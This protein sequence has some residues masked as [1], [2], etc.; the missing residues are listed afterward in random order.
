MKWQFTNPGVPANLIPLLVLAKS[1]PPGRASTACAMQLVRSFMWARQI[2]WL[3]AWGNIFGKGN[4][5]LTRAVTLPWN[6]WLPM[7]VP[8]RAPG[9]VMSSI[10]LKSTSRSGTSQKEAKEGPQGNNPC[11]P[12]Q[13]RIVAEGLCLS[14]S[15]IS[16][17]VRNG[18][19]KQFNLFL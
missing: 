11:G 12:S 4:C 6:T 19:E 8:P 17:W 5:P 14:G 18:A 10:P 9:E 13:Y 16:H 1:L 2:T 3:A 7:A 15:K